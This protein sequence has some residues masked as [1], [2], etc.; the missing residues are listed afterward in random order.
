MKKKK[1]IS[2]VGARPNFMKV[3]PIHRAMQRY[4]DSVEHLIVHTGQH[5]DVKMS[6]QFFQDLEIP[7]PDHFLGVGSA[8]HAV[9]TANIMIE[10]EKVCID[11]KPDLVIVVGDVNSTI[12]CALTSAK[13]GIKVAHVEGGLRSFDRGMPEEIN[14][15]ATDSICNYCFATEGSA[16]D[17]L[18][19]ENFPAENIFLVGNTM[20]DSQK[21]AVAA[22][23]DSDILQKLDLEEKKY[24]VSTVHRPSNV[25]I[26]E[27]LS[28]ILD[29]FG[30]LAKERII[31]LPAHPRTQKNIKEFGLQDKVDSIKNLKFID[32]LGYIDFLALMMNSDFV[33]TDSGGIQE[34]TTALDVP[35]LTIR[36]TTERPVTV[37]TGSNILVQPLKDKMLIAIREIL[38][39]VRKSSSV[40]ELWDGNAAGRI[41]RIIVEKILI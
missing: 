34:E 23:E 41:A 3:A 39:G 10:F 14:R 24:V 27:Q 17:N 32:P 15:I 8:S 18:K 1:I 6:D 7:E 20:I 4:S 22:A 33:I 21:F 26:P 12:A 30:E 35:C 11:E 28:D 31:I 40:P 37:E 16:I 36:T 25:D 13:L 5:Y 2:V 38:A 9:Q 19:K 29:V